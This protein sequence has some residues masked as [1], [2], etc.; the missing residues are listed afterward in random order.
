M[1]GGEPRSP[2]N[3]Q[4]EVSLAAALIDALTDGLMQVQFVQQGVTVIQILEMRIIRGWISVLV[5]SMVW[6]GQTYWLKV[7][8]FDYG[9]NVRQ[10]GQNKVK[11]NTKTQVRLLSLRVQRDR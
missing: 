1:S 7:I 8:G 4:T 11:Y 5:V 6:Q 3:H 2:Y 10:K 9:R